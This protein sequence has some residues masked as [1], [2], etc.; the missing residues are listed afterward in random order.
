MSTLPK[1]LAKHMKIWCKLRGLYVNFYNEGSV[2][3]K[4]LIYNSTMKLYA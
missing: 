4:P 2:E 3:P 1:L